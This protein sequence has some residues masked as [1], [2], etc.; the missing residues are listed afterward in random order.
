MQLDSWFQG[1]VMAL[2]VIGVGSLLVPP[3]AQAHHSRVHSAEQVTVEAAAHSRSTLPLIIVGGVLV[4]MVG[5]GAYRT[6]KHP[7]V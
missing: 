4:S 6:H 5:V 2:A 7:S 3:T 1:S